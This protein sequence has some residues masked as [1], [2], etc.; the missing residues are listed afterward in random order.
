MRVYQKNT[1]LDAEIRHQRA[2]LTYPAG[3]AILTERKISGNDVIYHSSG[4]IGNGTG[5]ASKLNFFIESGDLSIFS[6]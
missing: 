4:K 5:L 3:L 6:R 2:K 1:R